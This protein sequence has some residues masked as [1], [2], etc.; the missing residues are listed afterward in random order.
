MLTTCGGFL[1]A[2]RPTDTLIRWYYPRGIGLERRGGWLGRKQRR[3]FARACDR[4]SIAVRNTCQCEH[5]CG[6][7]LPRSRSHALAAH[8]FDMNLCGHVRVQSVSD[9]LHAEID[10]ILCGGAH[11]GALSNGGEDEGAK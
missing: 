7:A 5:V 3:R 2:G 8:P 11:A 9:G 10:T 4:G 6:T 1:L